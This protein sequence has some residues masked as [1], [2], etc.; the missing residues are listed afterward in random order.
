MK[1]NREADSSLA[2]KRSTVLRLKSMKTRLGFSSLE[3]AVIALMDVRDRFGW[4]RIDLQSLA[5][6]GKIPEIIE[7]Q[8]GSDSEMIQKL[9]LTHAKK[10]GESFVIEPVKIKADVGYNFTDKVDL[11]N[12]NKNPEKKKDE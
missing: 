8:A 4:D 3:Q 7:G 1:K 10:T 5:R 2:M 6:Y 9:G 11:T 12:P